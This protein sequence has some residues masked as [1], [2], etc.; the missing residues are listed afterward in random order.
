MY[1]AT[2]NSFSTKSFGQWQCFI[3][4]F[5]LGICARYYVPSTQ[6]HIFLRCV[7]RCCTWYFR[8]YAHKGTAPLGGEGGRSPR[9]KNSI[10]FFSEKF[11]NTFFIFFINKKKFLKSSETYRNFFSLKLDEKKWFE[12]FF[13]WFS[14]KFLTI[15]LN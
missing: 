6:F 12:I 7:K 1:I 5:L 14:K 9:K 10:H 4:Y 15:F 2:S 11:S 3:F 13:V 8:E